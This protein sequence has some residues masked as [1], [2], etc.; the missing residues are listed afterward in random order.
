[1]RHRHA[2]HHVRPRRRGLISRIT[3]IFRARQIYL[4]SDGNVRFFALKPWHQMAA[5]VFGMAGLFWVAY[6]SIN[7]AFKDQLLVVKERRLYQAR[8]E[9]EDRIAELRRAIDRMNDKLLLDQGEYLDK[10]DAVRADYDK[11]VQRQ[12]LLSEFFHQGWMPT[13]PGQ[14][15]KTTS[16][17]KPSKASSPAVKAPG[18]SL[19]ETTFRKKYATAFRTREEA[20]APLADMQ[21]LYQ[22]YDDKAASLLE[23]VVAETAREASN[24]RRVFSRLGIDAKAVVAGSSMSNA[25]MGGPLVVATAANLGSGRIT[26]LM[27][28]V[29]ANLAEIKK[30]RYEGSRMPVWLPLR[31]AERITSPFGMRRDPL[32]HVLALH[33]GIDFKAPYGSP[34]LATASG[35]VVVAGWDG[36]YGR[37]VEIDHGFGVSTRFAHLKAIKVKAGDKVKRG[38]VVGYLGDTGRSTGYHLHYETRVN[39]RPINPVRFWK[40]RDEL[41]AISD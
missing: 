10:V 29:T 18:D 36:G 33:T 8:L 25:N 5:L 23:D 13:Q 11:L 1:M 20:L 17:K 39:G 4:R 34:V 21:R 31:K 27:D 12:R 24:A 37:L 9:Y 2:H 6:A 35:K 30:L 14:T 40:V 38:E 19:N 26:E 3:G 32:L 7:V 41:Q 15:D 16:D 22:A 28:Q